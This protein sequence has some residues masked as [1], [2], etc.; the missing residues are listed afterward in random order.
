MPDQTWDLW[1]P[2]AGA[3]GLPFCRANVSDDLGDVVLVH[4]AAPRLDITVGGADGTGTV[5]AGSRGSARSGSGPVT[6]LHG[7]RSDSQPQDRW[8]ARRPH[9]S[10]V[11]PDGETCVP[12]TWWRV[13]DCTMAAERRVLQAPV[14]RQPMLAKTPDASSEIGPENAGPC[15]TRIGQP[16]LG[17]CFSV[18]QRIRASLGAAR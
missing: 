14:T 16:D 7:D 2:S 6:V 15:L 4:A 18:S 11:L 5:L 9:R 3:I 10:P 8:P 13:E 17:T 12:S 1:S